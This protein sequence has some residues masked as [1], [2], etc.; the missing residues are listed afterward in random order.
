MFEHYT[1]KARRAVF[2]ARYE[3]SQFG[4]PYIEVEHLFFGLMRVDKGAVIR[5]FGERADELRD[6]IELR[7]D[8]GEVTPTSVDL[9][10]SKEAKQVL[11]YA[12]EEAERLK[13]RFIGTEHLLLGMLREPETQVSR[14]LRERG[15]EIEKIRA[16]LAQQGP[17]LPAVPGGVKPNAVHLLRVVDEEWRLIARIERQYRVPVIGESLLFPMPDGGD[18]RYRIVDIVWRAQ[19]I[20]QEYRLVDPDWRPERDEA[21][22]SRFTE[23]VLRVHAE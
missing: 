12:G 11:T 18:R 17:D 4:S 9:P 22:P 6:E 19:P 3:A 10:L 15:A 1:D 8:K 21:P 20:E 2:F 5:W 14:V 13:H 7:L 16:R 23:I